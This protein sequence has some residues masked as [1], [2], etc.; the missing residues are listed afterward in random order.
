MVN[1]LVDIQHSSGR[2]RMAG[3]AGVP[4]GLKK[5]ELVGSWTT[6]AGIDKQCQR[7]VF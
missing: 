1:L 5:S 6:Y 4:D 2:Q 3:I 7:P